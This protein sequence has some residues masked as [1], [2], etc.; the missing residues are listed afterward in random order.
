[1]RKISGNA[2]FYGSFD[3]FHHYV[4]PLIRNK[5]AAMTRGVRNGKCATP[6][7]EYV[8]PLDAAHKRGASRPFII[9]KVLLRYP[10]KDEPLFAAGRLEDIVSAVLLEHRPF[11]A[12]FD[13]I[14]RPCHLKQ[15]AK[16]TDLPPQSRQPR[17]DFKPLAQPHL[18]R[19][20]EPLEDM[21]DNEYQ[22]LLER[23]SRWAASPEKKIHM[24]VAIVHHSSAPLA[25]ERAVKVFSAVAASKNAE[26]LVRSA[27][28]S[29]G[30]N[31]GRILWR[32]QNG[33]VQIHPRLKSHVSS[34]DW[35]RPS[36]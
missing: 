31:Y 3:D 18:L 4:G 10:V 32:D 24:L 14:C 34:Y 21:S 36:E 35:R 6:D 22:L 17:D 29:G 5:I 26:G 8:G 23:V 11:D 27:M 1:M 12:V 15:D 7:C 30:N 2:L 28:T 13:F 33:N 19:Q 25:F 16:R 9:E 20:T